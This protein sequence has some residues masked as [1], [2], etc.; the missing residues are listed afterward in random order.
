MGS[1]EDCCQPRRA[2]L[3]RD[4]RRA[5]QLEGWPAD[6]LPELD[7]QIVVA[8]VEEDGGTVWVGGI[9]APTGRLCAI[10]I[11]ALECFG[12]DGSFRRGVVSLF[13]ENGS[14]WVDAQNGLWRW[15][16]GPPK[17]YTL[18]SL[19]EINDF[20]KIEGGPLLIAMHGVIELAGEKTKPY[21]VGTARQSVDAVGC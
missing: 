6:P 15:K 2:P 20:T 16:P 21:P 5:C 13:E 19:R 14:L 10:G 1:L 17:S 12:Q 7:G 11:G 4:F 3:D 8:L 18:P 9:A